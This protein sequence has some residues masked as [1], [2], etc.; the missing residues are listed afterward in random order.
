MDLTLFKDLKITVDA[1]KQ[2]RYDIL[3]V[4]STVPTTMGLQAAISANTG[5]ASSKG[6]DISL[7]YTKT[8]SKSWWVSAR[9]NFT[10]ATS[11]VLVNEEPNYSAA[12][13]NLSRVGNSMNQ[14]YGLVAERLFTD[15]VEVA[16]SPVQFGDIMAGDI[17]YRDINGD[18]KIS[19]EDL[20]PIGL[21]TVPEIV[22]GFGFSVGYKSFDL[23]A[24]FQGDARTSFQI[25]PAS[26]TPFV[27]QNGLLSVISGDHWSENDRN[28][29]AFWPRLNN[30]FSE[31]NDQSS[32]WWLR[33]GAF[34]RLKSAELG[35]NFPQKL[36][37]RYGMTSCRLYLNGTNL[38]TFSSFKLWDPEMGASGLGYPIQRV[39]NVGVQIGL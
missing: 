29:Y 12:N 34:M 2:H 17:K 37:K 1:Y 30:I 3:M 5:E 14:I 4:R 10:Y 23:S 39:M 24:F 18:G 16:N 35:Y 8:L 36:L 21:P 26:I 6:V 28:P 15:D 25:N 19:S 31:N 11:E 32:S 13:A 7:D 27:N 22:Y 38:L 20:V 9:G 33:D